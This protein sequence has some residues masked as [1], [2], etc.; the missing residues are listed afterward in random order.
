MLLGKRSARVS[1]P[2]TSPP[3]LMFF[4]DNKLTPFGS[5]QRP[6]QILDDDASVD[7][8]LL[9]PQ[10]ES[11]IHREQTSNPIVLDIIKNH[12]KVTG[13]STAD[14]ILNDLSSI[15]GTALRHHRRPQKKSSC[16][17]NTLEMG[18]EK[19]EKFDPWS[20]KSMKQLAETQTWAWP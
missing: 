18:S 11:G 8:E 19:A 7:Y 14:N 12:E 5:H 1:I 20:F 10:P 9:P 17:S 15:R 2:T 13:L 3:Q 4:K 16:Q 6:N